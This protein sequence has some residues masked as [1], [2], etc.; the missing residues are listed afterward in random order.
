VNLVRT[1]SSGGYK[2]ADTSPALT[3]ISP[4]SPSDSSRSLSASP[5]LRDSAMEG[6]V[7]V[8][9]E[10]LAIAEPSTVL[11]GKTI[12]P[13]SSPPVQTGPTA[14]EQNMAFAALQ[15]TAHVEMSKDVRAEKRTCDHVESAD[16]N[17]RQ[18]KPRREL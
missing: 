18:V 1:H 9:V 17:L 13:P 5:E 2:L 16:V 6:Q 15:S 3:Q 10:P 12:P 8:Q 4:G 14:L 11:M 7:Q